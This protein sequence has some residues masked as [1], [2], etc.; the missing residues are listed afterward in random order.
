VP[1]APLTNRVG[2]ASTDGYAPRLKASWIGSWSRSGFELSSGVRYVHDYQDFADPS[3]TRRVESQTLFDF[4]AGYA[5]PQTAGAILGG[6]KIT[7]NV[8]NAFD[9]E[10]PYSNSVSGYDGFQAD[11]LGRQ[12]YINLR[13][14]F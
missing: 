8:I 4:A 9:E 6:A 7:L 2:V 11:L 1:G 3:G 12:L 10:P 5:W 14:R 13:R